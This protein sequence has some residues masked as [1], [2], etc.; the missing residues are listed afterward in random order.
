MTFWIYLSLNCRRVP[1]F[2]RRPTTPTFRNSHPQPDQEVI[3]ARPG[4][5]GLRADWLVGMGL[6]QL[7]L[8]PLGTP[9]RWNSRSVLSNDRGFP[10]PPVSV[11]TRSIDVTQTGI[12]IEFARGLPRSGRS[13]SGG[14]PSRAPG[15]RK[16]RASTRGGWSFSNS[17]H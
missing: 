4:P 1:L 3:G 10:A 11:P 15:K 16:A 7:G 12:F 14:C 9:V 17:R 8:K 5:S 6:F 2:S 13:A